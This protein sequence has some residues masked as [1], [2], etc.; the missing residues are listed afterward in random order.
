MQFQG[1]LPLYGEKQGQPYRSDKG[2]KQGYSA[3][4]GDWRPVNV[5]GFAGHVDEAEPLGQ[6]T[7]KRGEEQ[8]AQ[9]RN[10]EGEKKYD[11]G[12]LMRELWPGTGGERPITI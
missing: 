1:V 3:Q 8:G 7:D 2:Y 10:G 11:H 9:K 4:S 12:L 6:A 5:L